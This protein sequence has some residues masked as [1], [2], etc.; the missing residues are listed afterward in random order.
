M[1][2]QSNPLS[3][4][5]RQ[6]AI[7]ISL[8]SKGKYYSPAVFETTTT[9]EIPV[10]PMTAKDEL[11]FKTPDAMVTGQATVD[12]IQSCIPNIKDAWEIVNYDL[13]TILLGIRIATYGEMMDI[14]YAVPITNE[15]ITQSVNLPGLLETIKDA[16]ISDTATT[17]TGFKIKISPLT[18]KTLTKIQVAQFEQQ[19]IYTTVNSSALTDEKKSKQFAESFNKLNEIN[20]DLLIEAISEITTP[21]KD[22][23]KDKKQIKEFCNNCDAKIINEIQD[24]LTEIRSQAQLKPIDVKATEEQI[25]KGVPTTYRVPVTFDSSNFFE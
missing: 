5:Y 3:K 6:P 13:D 16:K 4:Y 10:L 7:Y 24:K 1:T 19:K 8:P 23:V 9:G 22:I 12:V 18:Y 14:N 15:S 17:K 20:F 25:K 21:E 11:A 2:E